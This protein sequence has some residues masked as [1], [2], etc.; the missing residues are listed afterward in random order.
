[1]G[2]SAKS[3]RATPTTILVVRLAI[4]ATFIFLKRKN[5]FKP[6]PEQHL[7]EVYTI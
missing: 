3:V 1:M 5:L 2:F 6:V 4:D 7:R